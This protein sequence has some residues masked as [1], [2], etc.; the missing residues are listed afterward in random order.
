VL[1]VVGHMKRVLDS[2]GAP[3]TGAAVRMEL[4]QALHPL[5]AAVLEQA[6]LRNIHHQVRRTG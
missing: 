2:G 6:V 5:P 1:Q 3:V 4:L